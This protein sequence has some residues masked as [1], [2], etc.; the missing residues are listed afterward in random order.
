VQ[1]HRSESSNEGTR[2]RQPPVATGPRTGIRFAW[3][4]SWHFHLEGVLEVSRTG[5]DPRATPARG[6]RRLH[7]PELSG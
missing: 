4:A 1:V 2:A 5:R 7:V 3:E 6:V